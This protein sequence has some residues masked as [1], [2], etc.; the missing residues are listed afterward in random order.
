MKSLNLLRRNPVYAAV[1]VLVGA[2][3]S[4]PAAE[5]PAALAPE[6]K[7]L[8]DNSRMVGIV[9]V[10][11]LLGS[12][13]YLQFKKAAPQ[14]AMQEATIA[15]NLPLPLDQIDRL[16]FAGGVIGG[17]EDEGLWVV[18]TRSALVPKNVL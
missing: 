3:A 10:K 12:P 5:L 14:C 7:F 17:G 18:R 9:R 4:A 11:E 13:A 1:L 2:V 15:G 16:V 8:P 6:A